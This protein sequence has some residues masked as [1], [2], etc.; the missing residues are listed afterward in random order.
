MEKLQTEES[1]RDLEKENYVQ[2]C[3]EM[4]SAKILISTSILEHLIKSQS[5]KNKLEMATFKLDE[6][7]IKTIIK[8]KMYYDAML[9]VIDKEKKNSSPKIT[10]EKNSSFAYETEF[11]NFNIF[12][13]FI[14]EEHS[15]S[16]SQTPK[17]FNYSIFEFNREN[18]KINRTNHEEMSIKELNNLDYNIMDSSYLSY[19]DI[20]LDD[21]SNR[22]TLIEDEEKLNLSEQMKKLLDKE[23]FSSHENFD[24]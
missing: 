18:H 20:N 23:V 8:K 2:V 5:Y 13:P 15:S 14:C 4:T 3:D 1:E 7:I 16:G 17:P 9:S 10:N 19:D 6:N 24:V 12:W 22:K 11:K 21:E